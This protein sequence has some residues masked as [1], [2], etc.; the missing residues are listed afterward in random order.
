M[1]H[2]KASKR[3][4]DTV[5]DDEYSAFVTPIKGRSKQF[6]DGNETS[7]R[8][9]AACA[10]GIASRSS[11][12]RSSRTPKPKIFEDEETFVI[13]RTSETTKFSPSE[14]VTP[15]ESSLSRSSPI[16]PSNDRLNSQKQRKT[17]DEGNKRETRRSYLDYLKELTTGSNEG[18]QE[19]DKFES[20]AQTTNKTD[21]KSRDKDSS[22]VN[23]AKRKAKLV[24]EDLK[25]TPREAVLKTVIERRPSNE[26]ARRETP[27]EAS[28][29]V[30]TSSRT[31]IPKRVFSLL[32][33]EGS[34]EMKSEVV[35][36]R[37]V[38]L[39]SKSSSKL[40]LPKNS[41]HLLEKD[42]ASEKAS[43]KLKASK[44]QEN[45]KGTYA[46]EEEVLKQKAVRTPTVSEDSSP[47]IRVSSRGHVP[48]RN[49]SLLEGKEESEENK[50]E[51]DDTKTDDKA[52]EYVSERSTE[53]PESRKIIRDEK[54]GISGYGQQLSNKER[55]LK[56]GKQTSSV[57]RPV[58][59]DAC[60]SQVQVDYS[61]SPRLKSMSGHVSLIVCC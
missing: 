10:D 18:K 60:G 61:D 29:K 33:S 40:H 12:R 17:Y 35:I 20:D 22:R 36:S 55:F 47:K 14:F 7:P 54:R 53:K 25:A 1:S 15:R 21:E 5:E 51:D 19:D 24:S 16:S 34:Q 42:N 57:D 13:T 6:K 45:K 50:M 32:E 9:L 31:P 46:K 59:A 4:R 38:E 43:P 11:V 28:P 41:P 39:K 23:S 44:L 52:K 2:R 26:G 49:F 58:A 37:E 27:D 56:G 48:K 3:R 8:Q 30:R